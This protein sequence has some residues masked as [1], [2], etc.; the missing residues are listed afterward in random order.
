MAIRYPDTLFS[1]PTYNISCRNTTQSL[2]E[3]VLIDGREEKP[4]DESH[5]ACFGVACHG[6]LRI[7]VCS[8]C[9]IS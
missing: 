3:M 4:L 1:F 8:G 6:N 9:P 7:Q 5:L 2:D